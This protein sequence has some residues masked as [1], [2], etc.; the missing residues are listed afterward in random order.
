MLSFLLFLRLS[1]LEEDYLSN[2]LGQSNRILGEVRKTLGMGSWK[3]SEGYLSLK[4]PTLPSP[5]AHLTRSSS[6]LWAR[7]LLWGILPSFPFSPSLPS[8]L[9][10]Q[11]LLCACSVLASAPGSADPNELG[12]WSQESIEK[13]EFLLGERF[14]SLVL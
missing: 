11:T 6:P 8:S 2:Q 7:A 3:L 14:L 5:L 9:I 13:A 1:W 4:A 10:H 12:L